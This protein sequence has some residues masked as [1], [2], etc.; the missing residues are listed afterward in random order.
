MCLNKVVID[1]GI[2]QVNFSSPGGDVIGIKYKEMDNV[3]ET[4][5][6]ENNRGYA[7]NPLSVSIY[8]LHC[9]NKF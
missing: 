4:K 9:D 7:F 6:Y 8:S 2:V 1:N 3:L 5:N